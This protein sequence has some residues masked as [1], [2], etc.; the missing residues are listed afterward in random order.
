MQGY[1]RIFAHTAS[2]F[3][4]R[5]IARPETSEISSLSCEPHP[6][7][8]IVVSVF[9]IPGDATAIKA[10]LEREHE[11]KL[12]AVQTW[13][14][15]DVPNPSLAVLCTKWVDQSYKNRRCPPEE[16]DRRYTQF[17]VDKVWRYVLTLTM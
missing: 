1:R 11:F 12:V 8:E 2:I 5:G 4:Q 7:E 17:G 9:E 6:G 16:W 15:E 3:F 14:S 13:T 10:F